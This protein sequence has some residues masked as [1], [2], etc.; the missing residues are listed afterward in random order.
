MSYS[1]LLYYLAVHNQICIMWSQVFKWMNYNSSYTHTHTQ[2][3]VKI[4]DSG[5]NKLELRRHMIFPQKNILYFSKFLGNWRAILL[6][7]KRSKVMRN[8][9]RILKSR[10]ITL[11]I[12]V[13]M[14]KAVVFPVM[15][16]CES[17]TIKKAECQRTD[18]FKLLCWRRLLR[19]HWTARRPN[20]QP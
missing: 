20:H 6:I 9:D 10:D 4:P 15:Y 17:W 18:A 14:V 12:K 19:V 3:N 13:C 1:N 8:L 11:L 7:S 5:N 2:T 16:G